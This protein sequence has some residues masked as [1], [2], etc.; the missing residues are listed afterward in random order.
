MICENKEKTDVVPAIQCTP[1]SEYLLEKPS[2]RQ[3]DETT[4]RYWL[5]TLCRLYP[6]TPRELIWRGVDLYSWRPESLED[7]VADCRANPDKYKRDPPLSG[8]KCV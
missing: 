1:G 4:V 7:L 2:E 8:E 3:F 5:D 6:E